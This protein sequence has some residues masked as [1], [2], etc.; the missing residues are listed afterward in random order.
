MSH[1]RI[2][3]LTLILQEG[4]QRFI[5]LVDD[6]PEAAEK[7]V[8]FMYTQTYRCKLT[9]KVGYAI[10][11]SVDRIRYYRVRDTQSFLLIPVLLERRSIRNSKITSD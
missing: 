10:S 5:Y 1:L 3:K 11:S 2:C 8:D 9:M 4:Y 6:D 7:M